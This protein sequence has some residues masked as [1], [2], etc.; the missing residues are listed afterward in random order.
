MKK[1][2]VY[3]EI[4]EDFHQDIK[5][6]AALEKKTMGQYVFNA[7]VEYIQRDE[8]LNNMLG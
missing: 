5:I 3:I 7:I 4:P 2:V 6:R 8:I 1:K